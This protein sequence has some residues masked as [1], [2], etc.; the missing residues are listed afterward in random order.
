[1]SS[2]ALRRLRREQEEK[3]QAEQIQQAISEEDDTVSI[4]TEKKP[5]NA[6]DML[7]QGSED[8]AGSVHDSDDQKPNSSPGASLSN[9][10]P[11]P[12]VEPSTKSKP[13]KKKKKKGKGG[14][15]KSETTAKHGGQ[16]QA[17][18]PQDEIDAA[19]ASLRVKS[20]DGS[21]AITH[22]KVDE[23]KVQLCRLLAVESKHLN[24]V[25]EMKRLFG[26]IMTE[27]ESPTPNNRRRDRGPQQLDLGAALTARYSPLSKGQ[28]LS[29]L[30]LRRNVFISGKEEWPKA[31]SGG[32]GMEMVRQLRSSLFRYQID[33][34]LVT[35]FST[36][37]IYAQLTILVEYLV[38]T[39]S[40]V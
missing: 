13:N 33:Q 15:G 8:E 36:A 26:N 6:F 34:N 32:L 18:E 29:G 39:P 4:P 9:E 30:A 5:F 28:G 19:L 37:V 38:L 21:Y 20:Q 2:R 11:L 10:T 27:D 3:R 1:M 24:A 35:V 23:S 12:I 16:A 7:D 25:N 40:F 14:K 17:A 31:P 22:T